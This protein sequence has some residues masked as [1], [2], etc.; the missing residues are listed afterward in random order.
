MRNIQRKPYPAAVL[1]Q[2]G[3]LGGFVAVARKRRGLTQ[4]AL[5]QKAGLGRA[6]VLR[7]ERGHPATEVGAWLSVL[8]ALGLERS[9]ARLAHPDDD[10][11][12]LTLERSRL[13]QRARGRA[14]RS[15]DDAF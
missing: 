2:L 1:D 8:W 10:D 3:R 12:G 5:A 7:I 6:T 9:A 4:L 13:P 11:E 14:S 15:L